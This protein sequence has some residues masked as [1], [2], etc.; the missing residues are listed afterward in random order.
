MRS[1][2][3]CVTLPNHN[4]LLRMGA[5]IL[6]KSAVLRRDITVGEGES[7]A[8][9]LSIPRSDGVDIT[10]SV[11]GTISLLVAAKLTAHR[12]AYRM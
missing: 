11:C 9:V 1:L 12:H 10:T 2:R 7:E 6:N 4:A 8:V 5:A 3:V